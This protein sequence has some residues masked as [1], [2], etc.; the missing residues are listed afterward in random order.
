MYGP[1]PGAPPQVVRPATRP[2]KADWLCRRGV[3]V[4]AQQGRYTRGHMT[5]CYKCGKDKGIC[6]APRLGE[7]AA[8][9]PESKSG[10]QVAS[11]KTAAAPKAWQTQQAAGKPEQEPSP[12]GVQAALLAE[13]SKDSGAG[14]ALSADVCAEV[15]PLI[16]A[17]GAVVASLAKD[18]PPNA[19][20]SSPS[21]EKVADKHIGLATPHS[22]AAERAGAETALRNARE[23]LTQA[24]SWAQPDDA[25]VAHC[26]GMVGAAE[27]RVAKATKAAPDGKHFEAQHR[28]ALTAAK[29]AW[30]EVRLKENRHAA[31]GEE[32]AA[33]RKGERLAELDKLAQY[34]QTV[35]TE[36]AR[37]EEGN[38]KAH[39]ARA[40][41][42]QLFQAEVARIIDKRIVDALA[43]A[44][45][46]DAMT[47]GA[48]MPAAAGAAAAEG[49]MR[50][51]ATM[52]REL[53]ELTAKM[54]EQAQ[55]LQL[56]Q[57]SALA[58]DAQ[59][60]CAQTLAQ[61]R[62]LAEGDGPSADAAPL[63][64]LADK[65]QGF[66]WTGQILVTAEHWEKKNFPFSL[67]E[68]AACTDDPTA[69]EAFVRNT[70]AEAWGAWFPQDVTK[71]TVVPR[72]AATYLFSMLRRF[73]VAPAGAAE[74]KHALAQ[75]EAIAK[76]RCT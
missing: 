39:E 27:A 62:M 57:A 66:R 69:S 60:L 36:V 4:A 76:R 7:A 52:A 17:L 64:T 23:A 35:R 43:P 2:P 18:R 42:R 63:P 1:P 25:H 11:P 49:Q 32:K 8:P 33:A 45:D 50:A 29:A 12:S 24:E 47:D 3:C 54:A 67:A 68:L 48:V 71:D 9:I 70:F 46:S 14:L 72:Q 61:F 73:G 59:L 13:A 19:L 31:E 6:L 20:H 41:T 38:R 40:T 22:A 10:T 5:V 75:T 26:K 58:K 37:L 15:A 28:Q 74:R 55:A 30:E 51:Q 16:P 21:A 65:D 44:A 34:I 53:E 56:L